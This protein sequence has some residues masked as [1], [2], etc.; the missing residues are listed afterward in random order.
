MERLSRITAFLLALLCLNIP[1]A[2]SEND[3]NEGDPGEIVTPIELTG[4]SLLPYDDTFD[5][6]AHTAT[7]TTFDDAEGATFSYGESEGDYS[8]PE[9]PSYTNVGSYTIYVKATKEGFLD[10]T[11]SVTVTITPLAVTISAN[12][13]SKHIGFEDPELDYQKIGEVAGYPLSGITISRSIGETVGQYDITLTVNNEVNPNYSITTQDSKLTIEDHQLSET[14]TILKEATCGEDGSKAK[15]CTYTGCTALGETTVIPATEEHQYNEKVTIK[16]K[17]C[18]E[19]GLSQRKCAIC[20]STKDIVD[21]ATGH[22]YD[23]EFTID[24][25]ASCTEEGEQSIHCVNCLERK[26]VTVIP[27]T[28]HSWDE[29]TQQTVPTCTENGSV[30][31]ACQHCDATKSDLMG[32]LGHDFDT[33]Y[34]ID[35]TATCTTDGSKSQ[36]CKRANCEE[37]QNITAI[38]ATGH[39]WD[40]GTII[41]TPT[42]V[43]DGE[44]KYTCS[45]CKNEK[46]EI[47][48][49]IGHEFEEVFTVDKA[50]TC[51][52]AGSQSKHCQHEGCTVTDEITAIA[53]LGHKLTSS[54]IKTEATCLKDGEEVFSCSQCSYSEIH[55]IAAIGHEYA[56]EYTI[57]KPASCLEDGSESKHC[58]HEN[59]TEKIG[60]KIIPH[61]EHLWGEEEV[62][63]EPTCTKDGKMGHTCQKC[64]T[65]EEYAIEKLG[66]D[67]SKEFTIDVEATCEKLGTKSKHC[68][69]CSSKIETTFIPAKG[70]V[71]GAT[72]RENIVEATCTESGHYDNVLYCSVCESIISSQEKSTEPTGHT[73]EKA[74]DYITKPTCEGEGLLHSTCIHCGDVKTE[75]VDALGHD[76]ATEFTVDK[77]A[78]CTELGLQ[79]KHCSRC[80]SKIESQTIPSLGHQWDEGETTTV[81]SCMKAGVLTKK[82][83]RCDATNESMIDSLGHNFSEELLIDRASTCLVAGS[84]SKHCSRCEAKKDS[85]SLPLLAHQPGVLEKADIHPA[86]CTTNG[87]YKEVIACQLCGTFLEENLKQGDLA[88]GHI[89]DNGTQ[90]VAATCTD[91]G[92]MTY[93][94][95]VCGGVEIKDI[96]PL[97]H[98]Y[99]DTFVVDTAATCL[100]KGSQSK[101]CTRCDIHGETTEIPA[102]GHISW[103]SVK[104][105]MVEPKCTTQGSYDSVSYCLACNTMIGR[106]KIILD[107]TGHIWNETIE[108][109]RP[110]C[111][112]VGITSRTCRAC[113]FT[114]TA[115]LEPLGHA[116][117]DTF[118][119]D[120]P[121]L[122]ESDG[123]QS[124]HCQRCDHKEEVTIIPAHG[125]LMSQIDTIKAPLCTAA[126]EKQTTCEY[127]GYTI[128]ENIRQ[129][130]HQYPDTLT[131]TIAPTCDR[132]G[133][134]CKRCTRCDAESN[135]S[136]IPALGHHLVG[137]IDTLQKP[138]CLDHGTVS[139]FCDRCVLNIKQP[140]DSLGHQFAVEYT[141]DKKATCEEFGISTRHCIRCEEKTDTTTIEPIGHLW[142]EGHITTLPTDTTFGALTHNCQHEGCL[143]LDTTPLNKLV[144]LLSDEQ[145]RILDIKVEGYCMGEEESIAYMT[146]PNAGTPFEYK[147]VF[148]EEAKAQGFQ[149]IDWTSTP[150]NE[151]LPFNIPDHCAD[152]TYSADL[153]F[154]NEDTISSPTISF[155]FTVNLSQELTVAIFRDVVSIIMDETKEYKTFQWYHNNEMIEGATR[156]YY[157]EKDGLSGSYYVIINQGTDNEIR[158][159]ARDNWYNPLNKNKDVIVS[160]NPVKEAA[161]VK[162]YNF[163]SNSHKITIYNEYGIILY[164]TTFE[165]DEHN[166]SALQ[167][168]A[169]QYFIDVDGLRTKMIK[170]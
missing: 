57:D 124:K 33:E 30:L 84:Q 47:I 6:N 91:L 69:R 26:E 117:S 73:Y 136:M 2:Y 87:S 155:N 81:P 62:L 15:A 71:E 43:L 130:G 95:T 34:T 38:T 143:S 7:I 83:L 17:T 16:Q 93:I 150:A 1:L 66:H 156:P 138:N 90:S 132:V 161:T 78:S 168:V 105:N 98:A 102:T 49:A 5:G 139:Q 103:K 141:I 32:K 121:A 72:K 118:T 86:T 31:Y 74:K 54:A 19:D 3:E 9:I 164:E 85:V 61:G 8:L 128:T 106:E 4:I 58:I 24:Q 92:K 135:I 140:I 131:V 112:E 76:Y 80:D 148:S 109:K 27:A 65:K 64:G 10:Y 82:C 126:G 63:T 11:N 153:T 114:Q 88:T 167:L 110:T 39:Q 152:G 166:I 137:A 14:F 56:E 125:H 158:S 101:H 133:M 67:Y 159:C 127:C 59:C 29:G 107:S 12:A 25:Q 108:A 18:T 154:R 44:K 113:M 53:A 115:A 144:A 37:K 116:I 20:G 75:V 48:P 77:E 23:E 79:S 42:C 119:I 134:S 97:G 21:P 147:M 68:T 60:D 120:V 36:H 165:G 99:A 35:L 96:E 162:L 28:G 45:S 170:Q 50:P 169:G 149:N 41:S 22:V 46:S 146:N 13:K 100:T 160:P 111:T 104:E 129:L 157:Q 70:H 163:D 123:T 94:C 40:E 151:Q 51:E 142:D 89:W 122:C 145:G 55:P 52:E